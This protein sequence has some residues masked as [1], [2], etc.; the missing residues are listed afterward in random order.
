[1]QNDPMNRLFRAALCGWL[2][3]LPAVTRADGGAEWLQRLQAAVE[4]CGDYA[5]RFEVST[6]D[7]YAASGEYRVSGERY[8]LSLAPRRIY[9]E[10]RLRYE[11]NDQTREVVIDAVDGSSRQLLDNP[12]HAFDLVGES[13]LVETAAAEGDRVTLRLKPRTAGADAAAG[14]ASIE[15]TLDRRTALP[16]RI[17][18]GTGEVRITIRLHAF[19]RSKTPLPAFRV[20]DFA[21]YEVIDFR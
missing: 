12:V 10:A 18:Y 6:S 14:E 2:A 8:L 9:G 19:E 16:E 5:A 17:V 15:L 7:G 4:A 11:V 13:Y 20:E 21:G 1:M 3:L